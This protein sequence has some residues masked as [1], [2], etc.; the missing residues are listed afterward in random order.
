MDSEI[1]TMYQITVL[2]NKDSVIESAVAHTLGRSQPVIRDYECPVIPKPQ[3]L[4]PDVLV[5]GDT[6]HHVVASL[7]EHGFPHVMV[8]GA[9][10]E[11]NTPE[12]VTVFSITELI[13]HVQVQSAVSLF[14]LEHIMMAVVPGYASSF[15]DLSVERGRDLI[16]GMGETT[17]A[18]FIE[19]ASSKS[20]N[21]FMF[22]GAIQSV[23]RALRAEHK[24]LC[25]ENI[26]MGGLIVVDGVEIYA[27]NAKYNEYAEGNSVLASHKYVM[28]YSLICDDSV[29]KW[30]V[31]LI[32]EQPDNLLKKFTKNVTAE[33]PRASAY[34]L[35]SQ[36]HELLPH[37]YH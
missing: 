37:I 19:A 14:I 6:S 30:F 22:V 13:S 17:M 20:V 36:S 25:Y 24:K 3:S 29:T 23:G 33:P 11:K 32:G 2:Y 35:C 10:L 26:A 7:R 34:V 8:C 16:S 4:S 28:F 21:G 5:F 31:T 9:Y 18:D 12:Y 27:I 15:Q 1:L